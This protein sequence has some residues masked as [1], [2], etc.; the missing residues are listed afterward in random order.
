MANWIQLYR[1]LQ[2]VTCHDGFTLTL[3]NDS[4][5]QKADHWAHVWGTTGL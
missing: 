2:T 5:G 3:F 4:C 1:N